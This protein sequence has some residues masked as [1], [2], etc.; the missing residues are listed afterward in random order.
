MSMVIVRPSIQ[1]IHFVCVFPGNQ[2]INLCFNFMKRAYESNKIKV[3]YSTV[4]Y[5]ELYASANVQKGPH[6]YC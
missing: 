6:S 1:S 2:T 4:Q 5:M 3:Q